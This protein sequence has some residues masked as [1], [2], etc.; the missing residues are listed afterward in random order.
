[1]HNQMRRMQVSAIIKEI[2]RVIQDELIQQGI[3]N[4]E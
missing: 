2:V 3:I 4:K 1:M